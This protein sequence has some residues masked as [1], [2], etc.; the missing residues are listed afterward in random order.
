VGPS[1]S[2]RKSLFVWWTKKKQEVV[3]YHFFQVGRGRPTS[4]PTN[5][6]KK[7]TEACISLVPDHTSGSFYLQG[8]PNNAPRFVWVLN[9]KLG[10]NPRP[11]TGKT[12]RLTTPTQ[13]YQPQ[14]KAW[15]KH[16]TI[17]LLHQNNRGF[18]SKRVTKGGPN[19]KGSSEPKLKSTQ[20]LNTSGRDT[21]TT[22][23]PNSVKKPNRALPCY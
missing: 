16:I 10:A 8:A 21:V 17:Q 6:S 7:I 11:R 1:Y 4:F 9:T 3:N 14:V 20:T 18:N 13:P 2:P 19:G 15:R 23:L 12:L 5:A 22:T